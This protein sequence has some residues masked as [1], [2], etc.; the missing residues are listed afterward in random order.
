MTQIR[1]GE[2]FDESLMSDY[3]KTPVK[4]MYNAGYINGM[5]EGYFEPG[6]NAT[7][8]QAVKL[9]YALTERS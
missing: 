9:M 3:A 8:A 2:F 1:N 7:R 6:S 5:S 4:T